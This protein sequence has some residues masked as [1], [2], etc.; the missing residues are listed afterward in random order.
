MRRSYKNKP[1]ALIQ[2]A[3]QN[4]PLEL[5]PSIAGQQAS[6]T[7]IVQSGLGPTI[8]AI[9]AVGGGPLGGPAS[10]ARDLTPAPPEYYEPGPP[11]PPGVAGPPGPPGDPGPVEF[12]NGTIDNESSPFLH[13][14]AGGGA[15]TTAIPLSNY[16]QSGYEVRG[17]PGETGPPGYAGETGPIGSIGLE[18]D[19]G[20]RGWTGIPG[21][22]GQRGLAGKRNHVNAPPKD[23]LYYAFAANGVIAV[24]IL[25]Y[26][27]L[28]FVSKVHPLHY[29][30]KGEMCSEKCGRTGESC[31]ACCHCLTCG[32]CCRRRPKAAWQAESFGA[33]A[34]GE[35]EGEG[36][37]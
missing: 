1:S 20:S 8:T 4:T 18:G 12:E 7:E 9:Y 26:S 6:T 21:P 25:T 34:E 24:I 31:G 37:Y 22:K 13:N 32:C 29:V 28:E 2:G 3:Q 27:Y 19:I 17:P 30:F 33:P 11:G 36:E 10:N 14:S 15:E 23:W 16:T 5:E 35:G